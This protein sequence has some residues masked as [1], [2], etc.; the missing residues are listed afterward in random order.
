MN[1]GQDP[2]FVHYYRI[3]FDGTGLDGAHRSQRHA[4]GRRGRRTSK[5]YVDS[6]SRVDLPPVTELHRTADRRS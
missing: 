4:H 1:A 3:G 5:Y 6:Y 2:Y